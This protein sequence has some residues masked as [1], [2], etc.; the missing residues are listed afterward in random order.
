MPSHPII[1]RQG[2]LPVRLCGKNGKKSG[3]A[4]AG[5][6]DAFQ[7]QC[8]LKNAGSIQHENGGI[9]AGFAIDGG[10]PCDGQRLR[11][12]TAEGKETEQKKIKK[13]H[14][15]PEE[16]FYAASSGGRFLYGCGQQK[17]QKIW[18]CSRTGNG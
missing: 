12:Q 13:Q 15:L 2:R 10:Q 3:G 7:G 9:M 5:G 14:G 8:A 1:R 16:G 17:R 18:H 6:Y 11:R 4:L